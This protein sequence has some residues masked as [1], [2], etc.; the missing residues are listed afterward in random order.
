MHNGSSIGIM[1]K[2]ANVVV[3]S[4]AQ[5]VS[6]LGM[7]V[8]SGTVGHCLSTFGQIVC[9][10]PGNTK[11]SLLGLHRMPKISS[12]RVAHGALAI[13]VGSLEHHTSPETMAGASAPPQ[14]TNSRGS[15]SAT[16]SVA[17]MLESELDETTKIGGWIEMKKWNP[18]HLEWA[19]TVSDDSEDSVGW[20]IG[21]NGMLG[22]PN[23]CDHFQIESYLK[24]NV[25]ERFSVNPGIAHIMDGN[26][27]RTALM[28][29]SNWSL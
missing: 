13:P 6:G 9:Q 29:R 17:L 19:V 11:L 25:S 2:N 12:E 3:A 28:L 8:G 26:A 4:V 22:G 1:V 18:R 16:G 27:K 10:L 5:S 23:S 21:L 14:E 24:L 20:G 7:K 15:A